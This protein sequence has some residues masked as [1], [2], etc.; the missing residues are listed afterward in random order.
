[1]AAKGKEGG[2]LIKFPCGCKGIVWESEKRHSKYYRAHLVDEHDAPT[3]QQ[4]YF[5]IKNEHK[6]IGLI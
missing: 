6:I 2:V 1:M 3:G 5:H 4:K